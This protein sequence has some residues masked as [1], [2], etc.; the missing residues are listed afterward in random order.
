[1]LSVLV[2]PDEPLSL[3]LLQEMMVKLK[4]NMDKMMSICLTWVPF[5][6]LGEPNIYHDLDH[7]TRMCGDFTWKDS[8]RL[9][10]LVCPFSS[11]IKNNTT[12]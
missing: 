6:E 8:V 7:F 12:E 4:R 3:L 10:S 5:S 2:V 11:K 1:M 9:E